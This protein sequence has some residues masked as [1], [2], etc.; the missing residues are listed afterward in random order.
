[1]LSIRHNALRGWL[2]GA[3]GKLPEGPLSSAIVD[4]IIE[5]ATPQRRRRMEA[6]EGCE[7]GMDQVSQGN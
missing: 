5:W 1:M 2:A 6:E 3:I 4:T 7:W